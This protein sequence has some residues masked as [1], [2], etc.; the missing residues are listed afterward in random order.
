MFQFMGLAALFGSVFMAWRWGGRDE[1]IAALGFLLAT[2]A[3]SLANQS[4]YAHTETGVLVVD[5]ALLAGLL[6]LA[7]RSDR[8]W[9]MWAAAFQLV[10]ITVHVAS[11]TEQGDFAWAYAVG[12]I[13]W[14]YPVLLALMAGTWLEARYRSN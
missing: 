13:F 1:K 5:L 6:T 12:L 4:Q 10:G 8:F 7:L 2:L 9:P 14:S 11:M 3:T